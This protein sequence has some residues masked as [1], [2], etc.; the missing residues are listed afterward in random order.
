MCLTGW[1]SRLV[2]PTDEGTPQGGPLSPLLSNLML[3]KLDREVERRGHGF[4]RYA[5][6][7]VPRTHG[8]QRRSE[9]CVRDEGGPSKP[10]AGGRL[11]TTTGC[12][13]SEPMVVSVARKAGLDPVR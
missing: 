3:G 11:Q 12:D 5:D 6:D 1:S 4:V 9:H 7:C 8:Q 13:G 10:A 2:G